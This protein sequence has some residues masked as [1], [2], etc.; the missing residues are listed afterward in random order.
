VKHAPLKS[1]L[2]LEAQA[3]LQLAI[4]LAAAQLSQAATNFFDTIMMGLLGTQVLAAGALGA[5]TFS[6]LILIGTGIVSAFDGIQII[7]A[8]ALRGLKDT[9]VPMFIGIFA[10]WCIGLFAGYSMG[11]Q[12]NWG[13]VGLWFGLALGLAAAAG[14]FTWRFHHLLSSRI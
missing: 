11:L 8:G 9:R 4:P 10:Y 2:I 5:I 1:K 3:C 6:T 13:G 14:T 12:L 7:A